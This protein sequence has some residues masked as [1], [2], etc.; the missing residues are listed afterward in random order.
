MWS[1]GEINQN[2]TGDSKVIKTWRHTER[3]FSKRVYIG[4]MF[5]SITHTHHLVSF[6]NTFV[7]QTT[8]CRCNDNVVTSCR[9]AL[10]KSTKQKQNPPDVTVFQYT[11]CSIF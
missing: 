7:G 4:L 5:T 3:Q 8:H 6:V 2:G 10:S 9:A 1:G 11:V